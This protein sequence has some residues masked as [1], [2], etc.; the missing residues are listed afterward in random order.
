MG[1]GNLEIFFTKSL[2]Q[3]GSFN[4]DEIVDIE[5]VDFSKVLEKALRG[6]YIDSALIIATLSIS[7]RGLLDT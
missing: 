2:K 6:E 1:P 4:V 3:K 5:L 7:V